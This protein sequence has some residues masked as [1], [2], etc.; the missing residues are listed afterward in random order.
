V[1]SR[2]DAVRLALER[3]VDEY[4][5][6]EIGRQIAEGYERIPQTEEELAGIDDA[7]RAM[8]WEEPW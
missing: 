3:L 8:I 6:R 5:R 2:S 1:T 4:R 7:T